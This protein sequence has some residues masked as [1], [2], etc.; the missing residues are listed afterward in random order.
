M[1]TTKASASFQAEST[2]MSEAGG[3]SVPASTIMTNVW[4][5]SPTRNT[6]TITSDRSRRSRRTLSGSSCVETLGASMRESI[7]SSRLAPHTSP[8][9]IPAGEDRLI[10]R[11]EA[12][13]DRRPI[14]LREREVAAVHADLR[15]LWLVISELVDHGGHLI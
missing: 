9:T 1:A 7:R 8:V 12:R 5:G 4:S 14:E 15:R 11:D 13:A 6:H 3:R 2:V 10:R